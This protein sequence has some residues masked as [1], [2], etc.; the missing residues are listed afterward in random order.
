MTTGIVKIGVTAAIG[1][2]KSYND[3][4]VVNIV[5]GISEPL[6]K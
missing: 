1:N 5:A 6:V 4:R 3:A 2:T